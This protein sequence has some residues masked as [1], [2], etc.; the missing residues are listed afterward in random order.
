MSSVRPGR[1]LGRN[2]AGGLPTS[3][4]SRSAGRSEARE[5][6]R[7]TEHD[8]G[9]ERGDNYDSYRGAPPPVER[10]RSMRSQRSV[11]DMSSSRSGRGGSVDAPAVPPL[12]RSRRSDV[13][14][15]SSTS[16]R[17][18]SSSS[19]SS[20]FMDQVKG[21]GGYASSRT[22]L[23]DDPEPRKE[24]GGRWLRQQVAAIPEPVHSEFVAFT[25][26]SVA[27]LVVSGR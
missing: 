10:A 8:R 18:T 17:S 21:R 19:A 9:R 1:P 15:G 24:M 26:I 3:P 12:P 16:S 5:R 23:E 7:V 22:S 6:E 4:R 20:T 25:A 2:I 14:S 11:A 27:D 13:Q